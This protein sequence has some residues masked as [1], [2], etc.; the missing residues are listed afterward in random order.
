VHALE[1]LI[2]DFQDRPLPD[3]T[4]R[5]LVLPSLAGKADVLVGMRRSGKTYTLYQ[6]MKRLVQAGVDRRHMLYLNFEDDRLLPL[7]PAILSDAL[8]AFYRLDPSARETDSYLFFDEIQAVPGWPRFLRRV[9]DTERVRV[10]VTGSSAKFLSTEVATEFRGRGLAIEILPFSFRESARHAGIDMPT[11]VPPARLRS[12]LEARFRRFL[13]VGG[14][15]E[16]QDVEEPD[17]IQML[18]DYVELVLLRDIIERYG[19]GNIAAV[20]EFARSL[21]QS[22][23]AQFSVHK[24]YNDLKSRGVDVGKDTLYALLEHLQD[25]FLIFTVPVFRKSLRA[26][27]TK[28]KK[29]YAID[30]GLAFAMSHVLAEDIGSRLETA[31]YLELRRRARGSRDGAISYYVTSAGHEVDFVLGDPSED[32]ASRLVQVCADMSSP[33]TRDREVRALDAAMNELGLRESTVVTMFEDATIEVEHGRIDVVPGW[34]WMLL[35]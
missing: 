8:E 17:R 20:R 27:Q 26:R 1:S 13:E 7:T 2:V 35:G 33:E 15:P 4:P 22:S 21:L 6:E 9:L 5:D 31:V 18:Q 12:K 24:T 19:I 10:Y 11:G 3:L 14:F 29:A 32:H 23:A 28:P 25:A 30:P 34:K 16:A